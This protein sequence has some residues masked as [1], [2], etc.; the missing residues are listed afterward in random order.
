[1]VLLKLLVHI[2]DEKSIAFI[3]NDAVFG[4]LCGI[5]KQMLL[6]RGHR[7]PLEND[8]GVSFFLFLLKELHVIGHQ[9]SIGQH[10]LHT[11]WLLALLS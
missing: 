11:D 4:E 1:M 3:H 7:Q 8:S 5:F 6:E 2:L 9:I 10:K